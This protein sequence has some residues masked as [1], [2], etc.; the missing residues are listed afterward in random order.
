VTMVG[1]ERPKSEAAR[2]V[3]HAPGAKTTA[4]YLLALI[5]TTTAPLCPLYPLLTLASMASPLSLVTRSAPPAPPSTPS[6]DEA[7][8]PVWTSAPSEAA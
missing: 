4:C 7:R 6:R 1:M 2:G 8:Q 3:S 5:I